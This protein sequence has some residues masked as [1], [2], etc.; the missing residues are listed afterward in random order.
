MLVQV[1][2][3]LLE[4]NVAFAFRIEELL[5]SGVH[6]V[7][8]RLN[9]ESRRVAGPDQ[10]HESRMRAFEGILG[11]ADALSHNRRVAFIGLALREG[12]AQ[13]LAHCLV[14]HI[15]GARVGLPHPLAH[16]RRENDGL[17]I[18]SHRERYGPN[19]RLE[20]GPA[21]TIS[22]RL[23]P[24]PAHQREE[25]EIQA[26][27]IPD[28]EDAM[29]LDVEEWREEND[30][31]SGSDS[32][33]EEDEAAPD[34]GVCAG[35]DDVFSASCLLIHGT[36]RLMR[37]E[38]WAGEAAPEGWTWLNDAPCLKTRDP[39]PP[40]HAY[41]PRR[42][43][44]G[45]TQGPILEYH[46]DMEDDAPREEDYAMRVVFHA[47]YDGELYVLE[48]LDAPPVPPPLPEPIDVGTDDYMSRLGASSSSSMD[49]RASTGRIVTLA[50]YYE[51]MLRVDFGPAQAAN[52]PADPFRM[53]VPP[54]DAALEM[55]RS[56]DAYVRRARANMR[57]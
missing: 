28:E 55:H 44:H 46:P 6:H 35:P 29:D 32:D 5:A 27:P 7:A 2:H 19:A 33:D 23:R 8:L 13:P 51:R 36:Y 56:M 42:R 34:E 18:M 1:D 17:V 53:T 14:T 57:V 43:A 10:F 31:S 3:G 16:T 4:A 25:P 21:S 15:C 12:L 50:D 37:R 9:L 52:A 49:V 11:I 41:W 39:P 45:L 47:V 26:Q 40:T 22:L 38:H 20:G 54:A 48:T 30:S 24:R